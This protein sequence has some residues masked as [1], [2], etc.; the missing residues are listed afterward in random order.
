MGYAKTVLLSPY[1]FIICAQG[2]S[3]LIGKG[4]GRGSLHGVKVC[5]GAPII[6]HLL[7][8][9]DSFFF[10]RASSE[11]CNTI[12]KILMT[13]EHASGQ[14]INLQKSGVFYSNNTEQTQKEALST[15]LGV[16]N[17]L[18]TGNT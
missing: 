3:N 7:F 14:A 8:K 12:K 13:Y 10:F 1:Q 18:D 4:I 16:S 5:H 2:L 9:N 17:P 11:E 15:I 6:S